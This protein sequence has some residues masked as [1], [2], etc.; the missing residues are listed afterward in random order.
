MSE[1]LELATRSPSRR[2]T[3]I[4]I[5]GKDIGDDGRARPSAEVIARTIIDKR[6]KRTV[7][8]KRARLDALAER[9]RD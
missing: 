8:Q 9:Y 5:N 4:R 3:S 1:R 2:R 7:A 6:K